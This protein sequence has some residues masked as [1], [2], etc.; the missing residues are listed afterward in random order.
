[1]LGSGVHWTWA[2]HE[3]T[4]NIERGGESESKWWQLPLFPRLRLEPRRMISRSRSLR[5]SSL[6]ARAKWL[7]IGSRGMASESEFSMWLELLIN[8]EEYGAASLALVEARALEE[9]PLDLITFRVYLVRATAQGG[10]FQSD[11]EIV[12][13]KE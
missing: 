10:R 12:T 7:L 2:L 5:S 6:L 3:Q 8:G 9:L 13:I 1:M 4:S 11:G